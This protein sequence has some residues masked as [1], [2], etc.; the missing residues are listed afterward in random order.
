[1]SRKLLAALALTLCQLAQAADGTA[2]AVRP[3]EPDSF[4]QIV[5][6]AQGRPLVVL[7]WSLD[8]AYCQPSFQAL[9]DAKKKYGVDVITIATDPADDAEA[10]QL[11]R[12]KLA[13]SGL[14]SDA[15]AFGS[16]PPEQ[17]R[18]AIDPQWRG[19][20]PRTYWFGRDGKAAAHSGLVD[21]RIVSRYLSR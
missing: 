8:C 17:L 21:T 13:A 11:I 14:S 12:K 1:M 10:V 16:S 20:T 5:R 2:G 9:A 18:H 6:S 19:E 4:R 7:V 15:W 3:F